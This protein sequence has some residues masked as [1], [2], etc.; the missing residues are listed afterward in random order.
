MAN[1]Q[2]KVILVGEDHDDNDTMNKLLTQLT[3]R[4]GRHV[5]FFYE[6][7]VQITIDSIQLIPLEPALDKDPTRA[8]T[9]LKQNFPSQLTD[10]LYFIS[11]LQQGKIDE[12]RYIEILYSFDDKNQQELTFRETL[13]NAYTIKNIQ[14]LIKLSF[15]I[16]EYK[17]SSATTQEDIHIGRECIRLIHSQ[18]DPTIYLRIKRD[19]IM[20]KEIDKHND[21]NKI[22]VIIVGDDHFVNMN[23]LLMQR[24]YN[25][26]GVIRTDGPY[27]SDL[28]QTIDQHT[29]P[30]PPI[31]LPQPPIQQPLPPP[32]PPIINT[33]KL[34]TGDKVEIY[35]LTSI[36]NN[37]KLGVITGTR[38]ATN[39]EFRF[40]VTLKDG[41][42]ISCKPQN[43]RISSFAGQETRRKP[44]RKC[45]RKKK[46][47]KYIKNKR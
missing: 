15:N 14:N 46:T 39:N 10:L 47:N 36:T 18:Q 41:T 3:A 27:L 40:E 16:F 2:P 45:K 44:R 8:N 29:P 11:L 28:L 4:L 5:L 21:R 32:P 38:V 23:Q 9:Y 12:G 24:G 6:S 43:L 42:Q 1:N 33:P 20:I 13:T 26:I 19:D 31:I 35:G 30:P 37:G 25:I 34:N 17:C 22:Y 7:P